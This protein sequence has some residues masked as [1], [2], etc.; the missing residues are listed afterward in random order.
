MV[1]DEEFLTQFKELLGGA[2]LTQKEHFWQ[3]ESSMRPIYLA[4]EGA[5]RAQTDIQEV[6]LKRLFELL[7]AI[8]RDKQVRYSTAI[9][10]II[11]KLTGQKDKIFSD[12]KTHAEKLSK[13]QQ[14]YINPLL[15]GDTR[16]GLCKQM[17]LIWLGEK[18]NPP[19]T[20]LFPRL[21]GKNVVASDEAL[22]LGRKAVSLTASIDDIAK[23]LGL[24]LSAPL[25]VSSFD[26]FSAAYETGTYRGYLVAFYDSQH[27]IAFFRENERCCQFYDANAGAY[28]VENGNL[29]GFLLTYNNVCLP[30]KWTAYNAPATTNF[31]SVYGISPRAR[32]GVA[33]T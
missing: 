13:S 22:A 14:R 21:D 19:A 24:A 26:N 1:I 30:K 23:D 6:Q 28:R 8:P 3:T 32:V 20:T 31:N 27:A 25:R 17:A 12:L 7:R 29:W 15:S 5:Q 18:L 9:K 2:R 16:H 33:R 11:K 4:L 10:F